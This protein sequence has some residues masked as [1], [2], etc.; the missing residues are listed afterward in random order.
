MKFLVIY[1]RKE[2]VS[3]EISSQEL[4]IYG[5]DWTFVIDKASEYEGGFIGLEIKQII[6]M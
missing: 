4:I 6:K 2:G 3:K 5:K 1:G